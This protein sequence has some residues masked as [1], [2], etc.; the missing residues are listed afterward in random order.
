M[1]RW[2]LWLPFFSFSTAHLIRS[3]VFGFYFFPACSGVQWHQGYR[4]RAE[5]AAAAWS[6]WWWWWGILLVF[7][8]CSRQAAPRRG[9][10]GALLFL[11]LLLLFL[12]P[13]NSEQAGAAPLLGR[14]GDRKGW[15]MSK[16]LDVMCS[17]KQSCGTFAPPSGHFRANMV[18]QFSLRR[19]NGGNWVQTVVA[20]NE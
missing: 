2:P 8:C 6:S 20:G 14:E 11:L 3:C 19:W 16:P 7:R 4:W 1:Y 10:A 9:S 13:R 18:D 12:D 5:D 17:T 15:G